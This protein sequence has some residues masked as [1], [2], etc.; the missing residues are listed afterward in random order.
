MMKGGRERPGIYIVAGGGGA[1]FRRRTRGVALAEVSQP[2]W[3][4]GWAGLI[5]GFAMIS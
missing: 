4:A 1:L 3:L 2:G 5:L